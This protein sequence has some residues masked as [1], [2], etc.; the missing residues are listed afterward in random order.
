MLFATTFVMLQTPATGFAQ[1]GLVRR[2]NTMSVIGQSFAGVIIGCLMWYIWGYSLTFGP[3][4]GNGFI[5][6]PTTYAWFEN[7]DAHDCLEGQTIPH[8]LF[9][10][11]Q[12]TFALMV[13]VRVSTDVLSFS[14]PHYFVGCVWLGV[15]CDLLGKPRPHKT[16]ESY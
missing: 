1:G 11:F 3:D 8:L 6:D 12:M 10:A 4:V 9:A 2:K 16:S 7:V 5:G 13:P 14:F 15:A